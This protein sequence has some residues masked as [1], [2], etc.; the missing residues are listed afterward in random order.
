MGS[1]YEV[2]HLLTKRLGALKLLHR[3]FVKEPVVVERFIREASAAGRIQSPHI[4]ETI[5][6]GEL[7]TG[8]P[9]IFMEL[10]S[11]ESLGARISRCGALPFEE[12]REIVV[13]ALRGLAKAHAAGIVHRDLKPENLF[14][15]KTQPA[16][17]KVLDFGLSKF[18]QPDNDLHLTVEGAPMGT[19]LY[20]S[21][22]QVAGRR[23]LDERTDVYSLGVVLYECLTGVV[24]FQAHTLAALSLRILAGRYV[25]ATERIPGLPL[26]VNRVIAR[27]MAVEPTER[28][29]DMSTFES[30]LLDLST[31][32]LGRQVGTAPAFTSLE[33]QP[34]SA[35][36]SDV[37]L[38]DFA[39]G[40]PAFD[41]AWA[42]ARLDEPA[43]F[44]LNPPPIDSTSAEASVE[45][46]LVPRKSRRRALVV[47]A[48]GA[49][50]CGGFALTF[51]FHGTR[52]A[53]NEPSIE[54]AERFDPTPPSPNPVVDSIPDPDE[55]EPT[56]VV[57]PS[58]EPALTKKKT[59][60]H[61]KSRPPDAAPAPTSKAAAAGLSED[62][63]FAN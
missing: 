54:P 32:G 42:Q 5:D 1:V 6:A 63:P 60:D 16:F 7:P 38:M 51:G 58:P 19:P 61:A 29:P 3:R 57:V 15:T 14:I 50:A 47:V 40:D 56:Q 21:P 59:R 9:Y 27:A 36:S 49:A 34:D 45:R 13:Q 52:P 11:G 46:T 28:F 53:Q 10:L 8:E 18:A 55:L 37:S 31:S 2:E 12:A 23:D 30:A 20:M 26:G 62:N 39:S 33:I 44:V 25:P 4:V 22:E 24:P 35:A 17:V 48:V 41:G 43:S